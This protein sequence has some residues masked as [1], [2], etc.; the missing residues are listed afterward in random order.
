LR[1]TKIQDKQRG[2]TRASLVPTVLPPKRHSIGVAVDEAF[3]LI[4]GRCPEFPLIRATR[5]LGLFGV[6]IDSP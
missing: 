4:S 1:Q 2:H 5:F 3:A 6:D